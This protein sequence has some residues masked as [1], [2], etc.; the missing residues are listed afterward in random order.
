[1]QIDQTKI[2]AAIVNEAVDKFVTDDELYT[3]IRDG[4]NQR[5]DKVFA[6]K[7]STVITDAVERIVGEGFERNYRKADAFGKPVGEMTS[8]SKE[9]EGIVSSYWT[10]RVDRNGKKTDSSYSSM[11][12][13]EWMMAQ[14]CADDFSKEMKQHVVNVG[15][16]L[17]DHFRGVLNQHIGSMLSDV[18]HVQ[19]PADKAAKNGA[20]RAIIDPPSSP[21]G[22]A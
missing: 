16:A 4:I 2:E 22:A 3:R 21:I 10:D 9:L 15:G 1:M 14:I 17:K 8:I 5:I 19:T 6:D 20:G 7:V 13:A 11:S 12:R 18:F